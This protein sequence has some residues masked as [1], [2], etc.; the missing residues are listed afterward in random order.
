VAI[1]P[2]PDTPLE[3]II[4]GSCVVLDGVQDAGNV[5]AILRTTAAAGIRDIV[6]GPGCAGPWTPRVLRAAQGAHFSLRIREQ[7]DLVAVLKS[8]SGISVATVAKDGAP[9]FDLDVSGDVAWI[10]GNEGAGITDALAA[11]ATRR[12]TIPLAADTESLN[13]AAAAAICLFE[14]VRQRHSGKGDRGNG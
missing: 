10:F 13:V 12:T 2:L 1:I 9:L 7:P 3:E 8:Y 14:G 6:L 4:T 11:L 5:G